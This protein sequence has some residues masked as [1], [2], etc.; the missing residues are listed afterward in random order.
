MRLPHFLR[1]FKRTARFRCVLEVRKRCV[2][3]GE[4]VEDPVEPEHVENLLGPLSGA[5]EN[6]I[7]V[8]FPHRLVP[9]DED[10]DARAGNPL[11]AGEVDDDELFPPLNQTPEQI[12]EDLRLGS[13]GELAAEVDGRVPLVV[14]LAVF[15][16]RAPLYLVVAVERLQHRSH[17][18]GKRRRELQKLTRYGMI[19][20]DGR[21]VEGLTLYHLDDSPQPRAPNRVRGETSRPAS[22]VHGIAENRMGDVREVHADLMRPARNYIDANIVEMRKRVYHKHLGERRAAAAS[23]H[24]HLLAI[25]GMPSDRSV[26]LSRARPEVPPH[27]RVID[28][29]D[30][31]RADLIGESPVRPVGFRQDEKSRCIFVQPMDHAGT[32][33]AP[34]TGKMD[35]LPEKGVDHRAVAVSRRG[36]HD[37]ARVFVDNDDIGVLE[38]DA[39]RYVLGLGLGARALRRG[40]LDSDRLSCPDGMARRSAREI[41]EDGARLDQLLD[42][43][44]GISFETGRAENVEPQPFLGGRDDELL[45]RRMRRVWVHASSRS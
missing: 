39:Q 20:G 23:R 34:D 32:I 17:I 5:D 13:T 33:L 29:A 28:L 38:D 31:A 22:A 37:D 3:I 10:P 21:R 18:I 41:D 35:P 14:P 1:F 2:L 43:V 12:P 24:R 45:I 30:L 27:D 11:D 42:A 16:R 8:R 44:P 4:H 9:A 25:D 7:A 40:D 26:D 19:K 36:V 15:R 6:E